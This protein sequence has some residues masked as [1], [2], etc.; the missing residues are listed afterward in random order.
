MKILGI[1]TSTKYLCLGLF[2][3]GKIYEY[4]LEVERR[5][6]RLLVPTVARVL[7]ALKIEIQEIDYFACGLGPGSFTGIRV[8]LAAIKGLSIANNKPLI[9]ISTLDIIAKNAKNDARLIVTA[10][11][12]RR[13]LIYYATYRNQNDNLKR[14]SA[15][16]LITFKDFI[17]KLKNSALVLG[18]ALD[19][20]GAK[21]LT[22]GKGVSIGDKDGW[23]PKPGNLIELALAKIK[24]GQ[25]DSSLTLKPIYLYSQECQIK[26]R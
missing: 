23:Y 16:K 24:A 19:L 15:Y 21:I 7:S 9:G 22:Q 5:L 26:S 14:V 8:G 1:D 18:D 2:L 12:A 4:R 3:D 6:S 13:D 10:L 20:Y 11:D 25:L 17:A